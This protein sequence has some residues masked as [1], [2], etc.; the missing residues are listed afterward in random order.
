MTLGIFWFKMNIMDGVSCQEYA[1]FV[2]REP[3]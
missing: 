2:E 3:W 1:I